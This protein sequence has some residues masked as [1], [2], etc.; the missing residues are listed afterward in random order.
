MSNKTKLS[1]DEILNVTTVKCKRMNGGKVK[2]KRITGGKIKYK[3]KFKPMLVVTILEGDHAGV[4]ANYGFLTEQAVNQ[5]IESAIYDKDNNVIVTLPKP[6]IWEKY[7]INWVI[8]GNAPYITSS[9]LSFYLME[10]WR[11]FK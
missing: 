5:V 9:S 2:C 10:K 7:A 8:D 3:G 6:Q 11:L 4:S 1:L